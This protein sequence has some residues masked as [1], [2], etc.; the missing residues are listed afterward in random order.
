MWAAVAYSVHTN[1]VSF[2]CEFFYLGT[3]SY[4]SHSMSTYNVAKFPQENLII[5]C[6]SR[7]EL[8]EYLCNVVGFPDTLLR[9]IFHDW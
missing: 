8:H 1:F 3:W 2:L 9:F 6:K 5:L 7:I 4:I